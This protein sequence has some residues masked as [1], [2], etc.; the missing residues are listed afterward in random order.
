MLIADD[1]ASQMDNAP[2]QAI[3]LAILARN[4]EPVIL[5]CAAW[6]EFRAGGGDACDGE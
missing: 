2:P 6:A 4:L 3:V 5:C 1:L